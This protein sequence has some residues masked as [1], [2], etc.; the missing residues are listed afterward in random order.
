MESE[1]E[2]QVD[3]AKIDELNGQIVEAQARQEQAFDDDD[4][5]AEEAATA[6]IFALRAKLKELEG[7]ASIPKKK[8]EDAK[9]KD[10]EL[11]K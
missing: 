10:A 3:Q 1:A 9:T 4:E 11:N 5:E 8:L 7:G 6:E 2:A